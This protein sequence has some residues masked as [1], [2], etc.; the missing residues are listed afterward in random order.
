[1]SKKDLSEIDICDK[2]ITPAVLSAGW[3]LR[4]QIGREVS[5]TDG[6]IIVRGKTPTWGKSK[7][8]DYILNYTPGI[9]IA[10]IEA[11]DN[12]C[13]VGVQQESEYE[14]IPQIPFFFSC[15]QLESHITTRNK[16][17]EQ[18]M[19]AVVAEV[20]EGGEHGT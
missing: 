6:R 3:N 11:K 20:L 17:A 12:K 2:F 8:A 4:T 18:L 13:A 19:M 16:K 5:F 9:P 15:Y 1:M 7:R 14:D 10:I